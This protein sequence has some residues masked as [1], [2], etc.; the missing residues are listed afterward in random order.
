MM[1]AVVLAVG[2]IDPTG[3]AGLAAD[4]RAG[5][6]AGVHVAT[7]VSALTVQNGRG[8]FRVEPVSPELLG[9]QVRAVL[10]DLPV[11]AVKIGLVPDGRSL[12]TVMATLGGSG[13]P[14]VLDP[15]LSATS[16]GRLSGLGISDL[17]RMAGGGEILLTPNLD[18][19]AELLG[20]ERIDG[21]DGMKRAASAL[22]RRT[23]CAVLLKGG[24][25]DEGGTVADVLCDGRIVSVFRSHRVPARAR[26]TGCALATL[27]AAGLARGREVGCAVPTARR[28]ISEALERI[29]V[30]AGRA[31]DPAVLPLLSER[32]RT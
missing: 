32:D 15:V 24:H 10:E 29:A 28:M 18:E 14:I 12:D 4:V 23:G 1:T 26:G 6:A 8:V 3:L 17:A 11:R 2:G 22:A 13:V 30:E 9:A 19:A 16:G 25:Q 7:A 20:E 31:D 5:A 27:I 21:L